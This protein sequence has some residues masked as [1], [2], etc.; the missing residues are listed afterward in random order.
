MNKR[1]YVFKVGYEL[2]ERLVILVQLVRLDLVVAEQQVTEYE[3]HA[4][5]AR[6]DSRHFDEV[7]VRPAV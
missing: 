1:T 3:V 2:E 7:L 5:A 4:V 6:L